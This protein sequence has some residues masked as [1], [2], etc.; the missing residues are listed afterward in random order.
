M[1]NSRSKNYKD[2]NTK[3]KEYEEILAILRGDRSD[4]DLPAIKSKAHVSSSDF[5]HLALYPSLPWAS[6]LREIIY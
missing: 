1:W 3:K 4:L 5:R 2:R 6:L